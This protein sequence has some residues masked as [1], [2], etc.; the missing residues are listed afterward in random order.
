MNNLFYIVPFNL[1]KPGGKSLGTKNRHNSLT[2]L[3][4]TQL[5]TPNSENVLFRILFIIY[6]EI[7]MIFTAIFNRKN[8]NI[9]FTRGFVGLVATKILKNT[10]NNLIIRDVHAAPG[11]Y[12]VIRG[13]S[14]KKF[15]MYIY[16]KASFFIDSCADSRIF[17]HPNLLKY[18]CEQG[19]NISEDIVMFNGGRITKNAKSKDELKNLFNINTN[20]TILVF[21]GSVSSWHNVEDLL[22]LQDEFD[23]HKDNIQI[24]VGGG[25]IPHERKSSIINVSPLDEQ[26]CDSLIFLADACLLPVNDNRI[27]PGSPLKLYQ[28][29]LSSK[30]VITQEN[31][32]G[33]SDEVLKYNAGIAVDFNETDLARQKIVEFTKNEISSVSNHLNKN[34]FKMGIT[35]DDRMKELSLFILNHRKI[36]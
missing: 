9:F 19:V 34:K 32:I 22:K 7:F 21:T 16:E 26:G 29:M 5:L 27:S 14:L 13:N 31:V 10:K 17:N 12:I 4:N 35:W 23:C 8:K 2:K 25:K 1:K 3:F 24:I 33:Y 36:K 30:P 18:Y 15:F 6:I 20:K 11:E 28:Y